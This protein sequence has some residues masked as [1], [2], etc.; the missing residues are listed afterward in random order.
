MRVEP[1]IKG[2]NPSALLLGSF[3]QRRNSLLGLLE[4]PVRSVPVGWAGRKKKEERNQRCPGSEEQ[5]NVGFG[6]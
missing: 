5:E 4:F 3:Y 6:T 1:C 2:L